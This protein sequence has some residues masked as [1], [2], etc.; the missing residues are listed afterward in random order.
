[1]TKL[2]K[3]VTSLLTA[4]MLASVLVP[5][6]FAT[7]SKSVGCETVPTVVIPG[8]FQSD[9]RFY[10]EN[11][12]E[13]LNSEGET[14]SKP[15]FT[16]ATGDI[17]KDALE[18][19]L[20]PIAKTVLTQRD[21]DHKSAQA[22]A[23]VLGRSLFSNIRLD[24]YGHTINNIR[25]TEY[26]T[27]L[28]NLSKEDREYALDQIPLNDYVESVGLDHLYFFSYVSTGN[29]KETAE[30]LYELIQIAKKE[31]GHDKVNLLPISQGGSLFNAL[32]QLYRDK[33]L[34][35]SADV[36]RVCFIV[37]ASDGAAVLGDIYRYGLLDDDDAL[38]GYMFPSL[39]G[40]DQQYLAYL[41]NI[42]LRI[43]PNADLNAIL[44]CAIDT[45]VEDYLENS[46]C[47]WALIPSADYPA[48]RAK[49]LEDEDSVHI[50]GQ[51]DWYYNAQLN[52][53]KYILEEQAK[54]VEFF[55]IVD[56]NYTLYKICDSW[57]SVNADGIIHTD[58]ESLGATSVAVDTPLPDGYTQVGTYCND[59]SH[60]HIDE[61]RLIDA[62]TSILCETSFYFKGQDH[63]TTARN[64]V[65]IK[66]ATRI[67]T[68][69]SFKNVY[70]DPAFPQF[71]FA[72][73]SRGFTEDVNY[74][75][76]IDTSSLS[77]ENA[78]KLSSAI[79]AAELAINST[80]MTTESFEA[81][82]KSFY[83]VIYEIQNGTAKPEET[84]NVFLEFVTKLLK[85]YS[86]LLL[87]IFKGNG[88]S[89]I[90][91]FKNINCGGN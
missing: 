87:K 46:T 45:L 79:E 48:C 25:A 53:R 57:N 19:A 39:L 54:G 61:D 52:H 68:D 89:D 7:S 16:E 14:Y 3:A 30:R 80:Y 47:L 72:R 31:S 35:F 49:F 77:E 32:M 88:W 36:N 41:I 67:L 29:L 90:L 13:K 84:P 34:D 69:S 10:D 76:T 62:S 2:K 23:D 55:D 8:I 15:F 56:Y 40:D 12:N 71:N 91:L 11:G 9:V 82:K 83:G 85:W 33:G 4:V 44:D 63:E 74:W 43:M 28:L 18:N 26:N 86:E 66:L 59:P 5:M 50:V 22:I 81:A 58:S 21:K 1:M 78:K 37:P 70:S 75:K 24:E 60:N 51:T 20:W 17:V 6:S 64:G 65:I 73:D 38:Y 27:A 42:I